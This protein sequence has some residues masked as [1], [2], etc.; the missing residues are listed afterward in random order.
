VETLSSDVCG[1]VLVRFTAAFSDG[2]ALYAV[3]YA[4]DDR[5]PTLYAGP[6]GNAMGYCL[7]SEPLNDDTD[8]WAE[9]PNGSIIVVSD[10]GLDAEPFIPRATPRVA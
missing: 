4:T 1:D 2:D 9:I 7:V 5:P 8:S 10:R 6:L 3:R